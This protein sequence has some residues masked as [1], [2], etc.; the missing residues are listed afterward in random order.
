MPSGRPTGRWVAA[1]CGD[2]SRS[3]WEEVIPHRAGVTLEEVYILQQH[4]VVLERDG[5][6]P[7]L[8]SRDKSGRIG[9]TIVPD[10]PSCTLAV[11][12]SAGGHHSLARHSFRSSKLI[13][14]VSSFV[15]P[16]VWALPRK[17]QAMTIG[18]PSCHDRLPR[19]LPDVTAGLD[20]KHP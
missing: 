15:T 19:A 6:N 1:D 13:Y 4:L 18:G 8:V 16:Q 7:R 20:V 2:P 12:L 11:G 14:S 10:E 5:L 9:A 17:K 3:H